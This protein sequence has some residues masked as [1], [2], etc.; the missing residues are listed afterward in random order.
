MA[1]EEKSQPIVALPSGKISKC[2]IEETVPSTNGQNGP[3]LE[4]FIIIIAGD[5]LGNRPSI[6]DGLPGY[7]HKHPESDPCEHL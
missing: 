1:V 2:R 7:P 6:T 5:L 3:S 4:Q